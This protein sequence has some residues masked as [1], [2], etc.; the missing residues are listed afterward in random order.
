MPGQH[1]WLQN[2]LKYTSLEAQSSK[3]FCM[4]SLLFCFSLSHQRKAIG[5][6]NALA[7]SWLLLPCYNLIA[8]PSDTIVA[9]PVETKDA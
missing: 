3:G 6:D 8:P 7:W 5:T 2:F 1:I 9:L 4:C